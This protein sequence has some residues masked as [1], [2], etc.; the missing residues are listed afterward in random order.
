MAE[1]DFDDGDLHATGVGDLDALAEALDGPRP[2]AARR[3]ESGGPASDTRLDRLLVELAERRASDLVL[4]AGEP[5]VFRVNGQ[6]QRAPEAVLDGPDIEELVAPAL[7]PHALRA[8]REHGIADASRKIAGAG[9]FRINLH[10]ERGRAAAV[11]RA[12][13]RRVP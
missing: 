10:R 7:P 4:V 5:P 9:R 2:A 12:L 6:M 11:I 1:G 8:F 13:P 3:I